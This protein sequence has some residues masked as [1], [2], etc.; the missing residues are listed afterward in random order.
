MDQDESISGTLLQR[1]REND[2]RAWERLVTVFGPLVRS[3]AVRGQV[4]GGDVDDV[5]QEVFAKV[6]KSLEGFRRDR[7]GD[8]FLGWLRTIVRHRIADYHTGKG[9]HPVGGTQAHA[10]LEQLP[11]DG[12]TETLD[13]DSTAG[14][15]RRTL[16]ELRDEFE[17]Q[18]W[19]AFEATTI[20]SQRTDLVATRLG[21]SVGAVY[22]AK[23]RVLKRLRDELQGIL[24]I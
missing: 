6:S 15:V 8:T 14:L 21:M 1:V 11:E 24:E 23:S 2:G 22:V 18:T 16:A 19:Q 12:E 3:W 9:E 4:R 13:P 7:P 10:L 5:V 17:P 20:D